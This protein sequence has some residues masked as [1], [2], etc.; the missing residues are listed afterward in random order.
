MSRFDRRSVLAG[1]AVALILGLAIAASAIG[2]GSKVPGKNGVKASDIARG[3]VGAKALAQP[4]WVGVKLLNGWK[5]YGNGTRP[6]KVAID[7]WGFVHLRGAIKRVSGSSY[8]PFN[9]PPKY[10]PGAAIFLTVPMHDNTAGQL[11]ILSNGQATLQDTASV[12][13]EILTSLEGV[14][15]HK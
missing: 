1:M 6:P 11:Q 5:P 14:S 7:G 10:R 3:A 8:V 9:L 13:P 2:G 4:K 15:F 12:E